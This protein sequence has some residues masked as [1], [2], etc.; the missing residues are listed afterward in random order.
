M[1]LMSTAIIKPVEPVSDDER[2]ELVRDYLVASYAHAAKIIHVQIT[3]HIRL[4]L[5]NR[6]K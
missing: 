3:H 6:G 2:S 1:E 4:Y 5:E